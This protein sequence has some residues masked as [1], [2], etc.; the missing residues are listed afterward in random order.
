MRHHKRAHLICRLGRRRQHQ[1]PCRH[2]SPMRALVPRCTWPNRHRS[3]RP[4]TAQL[5]PCLPRSVRGQ[6]HR[7]VL[8]HCKQRWASGASQPCGT[9]ARIIHARRMCRQPPP[10]RA[11]VGSCGRAW[12]SMASRR[13]SARHIRSALWRSRGG[14]TVRRRPARN[15]YVPGSQARPWSV[16]RSSRAHRVR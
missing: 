3:H 6:P 8:P 5:R 10:A 7:P 1:P 15:K 13:S 2:R 9:R 11:V 4:P 12:A 16:R 14:S